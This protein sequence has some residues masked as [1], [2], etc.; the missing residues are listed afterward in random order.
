M[1]PAEE[2]YV[3]RT[4]ARA[5]RL[6]PEMQQAFL[7]TVKLLQLLV[8][9]QQVS[10][11]IAQG[12][13][14]RLISVMLSDVLL[15]RAFTPMRSTLRQMVERSIKYAAVELPKGGKVNGQLAISF[16]YLNPKVLDAMKTL[17]TNVMRGLKN[18]VRETVRS[19][20]TEGL[21]K[22]K[23]VAPIAKNLRESVGLGPTQWQEVQNFRAALEGRE[24]RSPFD[25]T[26]RDKRFD[27]TLRKLTDGKSLTPEQVDKMVDAYTKRRIAL[28]A[29][30][31]A[32]TASHDAN[33]LGQRLAVE[34]AVKLGIV[35]PSRYMKRWITT[36]DGRER[37]EH[38]DMNGTVVRWD[39]DYT[40]GSRTWS[41]AGS[42]DYSCRCSD[43][44]FTAR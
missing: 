32:R 20:I 17:D 1:T 35:D 10:V 22:G 3:R 8:Q 34:D 29:E 28:N 4:L 31:V 26:K 27:A 7:R 16:D 6:T 40:N 11:F 5:S 30:T 23:G 41:Y 44:Y 19:A 43:L 33:R 15:D 39:Q 25:Y 37:P 21:T 18:D 24:G 13:T 2:S 12:A 36:L 42:G 38:H 14:E 9:A